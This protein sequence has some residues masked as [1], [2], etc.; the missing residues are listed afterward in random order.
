MNSKLA[1]DGIKLFV[2]ALIAGC[3][4]GGSDTQPPVDSGTATITAAAGGTVT[5]AASTAQL[6]FPANAVSGNTAVT[7]TAKTDVPTSA[8]T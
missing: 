5:T 7:A 3:G 2:A 8:R 6:V 1:H 4:G